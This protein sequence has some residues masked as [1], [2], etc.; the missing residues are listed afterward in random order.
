MYISIYNIFVFNIELHTTYSI[1]HNIFMQIYIHT[2]LFAN[3][4]LLKIKNY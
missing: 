2:I 4:E 1:E 3:K